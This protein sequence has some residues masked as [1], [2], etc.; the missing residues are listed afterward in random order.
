MGS[1]EYDPAVGRWT[2]KDPI[3]WEGGTTG[4]Y[5]FVGGNPI[6]HFDP[7]GLEA[8]GCGPKKPPEK[9][10]PPGS[11]NQCL[12]DCK[13]QVPRC[14]FDEGRSVEDCGYEL[15]ECLDTCERCFAKNS[16]TGP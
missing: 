11:Y 15:R 9:P 1:R 16:S 4:L 6:D 7:T 10:C 13:A 12:I 3:R 2:S 8:E 14:L 5:E